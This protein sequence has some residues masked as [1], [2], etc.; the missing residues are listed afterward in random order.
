M[1]HNRRATDLIF[2]FPPAPTHFGKCHLVDHSVSTGI[3]NIIHCYYCSGPS[4]EECHRNQTSFETYDTYACVLYHMRFDNGSV[5][6]DS[7]SKTT[8]HKRFCEKWSKGNITEICYRPFYEC[9][10]KCCYGDYCNKGNI[11]DATDQDSSSRKA[12]YISDAV[13]AMGLLLGV[14]LAAFSVN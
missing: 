9:K 12:V 8:I 11:M 5:K 10:A 6:M 2:S 7:F 1:I 13:V 14:S 4:Y 3:F